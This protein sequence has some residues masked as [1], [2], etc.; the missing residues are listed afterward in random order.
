MRQLTMT[1]ERRVEWEE[2]SDPLLRE[3]NDA[4]VRP[5]AVALCDL[6]QPILRGEAPFPGP[7]ALGHE[8][9]AEVIQA[10]DMEQIEP[11]VVAVVPFQISCGECARCRRGQTGDCL[12]VPER[13]M[14]GFGPFGGDWGGALSDYVRVPFADHMLV[15][16][17]EGVS[18]AAVASASDNIPDAWRTVAGPL[19]RRPRADVLIV[20]G[21]SPSI[22]LY[23]IEVAR[24]LGARSIT[25]TDHDAERLRIAERLGA[26]VHEG[27]LPRRLGPFPVTVDCGAT[28]DSLALALRSAEPDGECTSTG[29][30]FEP[31]TPVPLLEMY[32]SGVHFHTGRAQAR[33]HIPAIL[34][35]VAEGRL[36]PELVTSNVV[37]WDDAAEAVQVRERKLVIERD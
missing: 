13:S 34:E 22:G 7:I 8:F 10:G 4:I 32:T 16:I 23:A 26:D 20:G 24:A 1:E 9:V 19:E 15:P 17:P 2:V 3:A 5:L 6:D 29:I 11:G 14:F 12:T 33:P 28:R 18:P 30:I 36:H 25:Y 37:A 35:L 27:E 21:G 31:E